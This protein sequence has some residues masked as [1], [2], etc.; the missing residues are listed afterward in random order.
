MS[1]KWDENS[2]YGHRSCACCE[3]SCDRY[4]SKQHCPGRLAELERRQLH[5]LFK[6]LC[7]MSEIV[8]AALHAHLRDGDVCGAQQ[9]SRLSDPVLVDVADRRLAE[10]LTEKPA[11]I[12][13]VQPC[14]VRELADPDRTAVILM[15]VRD[16]LL[17]QLDARILR[18]L[19]HEQQ[20]LFSEHGEHREQVS[21]DPELSSRRAHGEL[22]RKI[23][24]FP[25]KYSADPE[26]AGLQSGKGRVPLEEK[27]GKRQPVR[28]KRGDELL[29]GEIRRVKSENP[30]GKYE[31]LLLI[32]IR[33]R[34][35]RVQLPAVDK[36]DTRPVDGALLHIDL[37]LID[38][39]LE[40]DHL[41]HIVPVVLDRKRDAR[42][43]QR[44]VSAVEGTRERGRAVLTGLP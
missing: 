25:V 36:A 13:L 23:R 10:R 19:A 8:E 7:E 33:L 5:T 40:V 14:D 2:F 34:D 37:D 6:F 11:E 17:E 20:V 18:G 32:V 3:Q 42:G 4:H 35:E 21:T 27:G 12:L 24:V 43:D 15:D 39:A 29:L 31:R 44:G 1:C 9:I 38:A 28:Q 16:H 26:K 30:G 22:L 41:G